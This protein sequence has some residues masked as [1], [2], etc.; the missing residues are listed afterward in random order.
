[1]PPTPRNG[2]TATASTMMPRPPHQCSVARHRLMDG[3]SVSRPRSTV[4]PVV[5]SPDIASKNARVN[6]RCGSS[7]SS[8]IAAEADISSQ[9]TVT[10][11]K[12]S[13][14]LSSRAWRR[15]AAASATPMPVLINADAM[16]SLAVPS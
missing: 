13:R 14:G 9:P 16:N 6:D 1:M 10:S 12:P 11:R 2:S 8:G 5:V 15:V 4:E 7:S 3:G